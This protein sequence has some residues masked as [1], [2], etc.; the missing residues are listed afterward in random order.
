MRRLMTA[1]AVAAGIS[2]PAMAGAQQI[3]PVPEPAH[4]PRALAE[5]KLRLNYTQWD[6][7]TQEA[8]RWEAPAQVRFSQDVERWGPAKD[9]PR[10]ARI[11]YG[12]S[13][14]TEVFVG[15]TKARGA[16]SFDQGRDWKDIQD[17]KRKAYAIGI[18]KRW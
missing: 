17:R 10:S 8:R 5:G 3:A 9:A 15:V 7:A 2:I 6:S 13:D 16:D 14:K 18:S 11:G 4:A 12:L 1:C